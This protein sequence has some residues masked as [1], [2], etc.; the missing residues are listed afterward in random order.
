MRKSLQDYQHQHFYDSHD[1]ARISYGYDQSSIDA[2]YAMS[3]AYPVGGSVVTEGMWMQEGSVTSNASYGYYF[4]LPKLTCAIYSA[5]VSAIAYD[6]EA[7]A[8]Y[9]A[10]HT[11]PFGERPRRASMLV[12]HNTLNGALYSSCAGHPEADSALLNSMYSCFF[13]GSNTN[14]IGKRN[15]GRDTTLPSHVYQPPYGR[16]T[17][18]PQA[19]HVGITA[20]LN[21]SPGF[22]TSISPAGVRLHTMGGHC[23]TD[24]DMEGMFCGTFHPES[25]ST[26]ISVAGVNS[27][28]HL[29]DIY[30]ELRIVSSYTIADD[31]GVMA[32]NRNDAKRVLITGC[33]DGTLRLIDGR[34]I[35]AEVGKLKSHIG[36][37]TSVAISMDGVLIATTG[38]SAKSGGRSL[39]GLYA[40][41]D[42]NVLLYDIRY[43]GRGGIVHPFSG[44]KC[45]PRFLS[46]VPNMPDMPNNRLF[47]ASGQPNG[48]I[49]II[50]PFD[51]EIQSNA[52]NF[53]FPDLNQGESITCLTLNEQNVALGTSNG[54]VLQYELAGY[55]ET[56]TTKLDTKDISNNRKLE[57]I[58]LDIP[59]FFPEVPIVSLEP[60]LLQS[61]NKAFCSKT[62]FESYI[63]C[64]E[65][66]VS[67]IG[68]REASTFGYLAKNPRIPTP[69]QTVLD[70]ILQ[71]ASKSDADRALII[72]TSELKLSD[73][74]AEKSQLKQRKKNSLENYNKFVFCN[75]YSSICYLSDSRLR[76]KGK[77]NSRVI[78]KPVS[79]RA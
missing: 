47:I 38:L 22:V 31:L 71:A 51:S 48:G 2:V 69:R 56:V 37:V 50:T 23:I 44:A 54:N 18:Q 1:N 77:S 12:T 52:L 32:L 25:Q 64:R 26:H 75:K 41:P 30:Q 68:D 55:K 19:S 59:N 5:P 13:S 70:S 14:T 76:G 65:P 20:L 17:Q 46:F 62:G 73:A 74:K 4:P 29:L 67:R 61:T 63:L 9:V 57:K 72:A 49:G 53:I 8:M 28:I 43:L 7:A 39:H 78:L 21:N 27:A 58:P 10:S 11:Q 33:S 40:Y 45:G 6:L 35:G 15:I 3:T 16:I 60:T 66:T 24:N 34:M 36:G 42:P 79:L